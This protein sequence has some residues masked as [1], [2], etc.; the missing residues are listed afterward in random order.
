MKAAVWFG[1]KDVRVM[2]VPEPSAPRAGEVKIKV[3][4]CGICG[5]DLHEYLAGP[6]FINTE[7][8][9]LTGHKAPVILGHEF[10]GDIVEVG[11]GVDSL[12][13]GDR[14]TADACQHCGKCYFCQR[15]MTQLC[16]QVAFTGLNANGAFAEY[17]NVPV[18][19]L[20]KLSDNISY[21]AGALIEPLAVGF[22]AVRQ[23]PLLAG[24]SVVILGAGTIGLSTLQA[25]RAAG[26]SKI[27]V[28]EVARAR[29]EYALKLGA[30][31][32]FDP[33]EVDVVQKVR[34][35][36]GGL[37]ADVSLE[38]IGHEKTVPLAIDL[39]RSAGKV[40]LVGI[41]ERESSMNFFGVV[42]TEKKIT[43][44]LCYNGEFAPVI[45]LLGD[46]RLQAEPLI[47]G[48]IKIDDIVNKGFEELVNNKEQNIKI[49]VTPW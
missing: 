42:A 1:R 48:K 6:I 7:P 38:C 13:V 4:W 45:D 24:E 47:T 5:T 43:G 18:N 25:A 14:V 26:A 21:E 30:T 49:I 2:D 15:N 46:G 20:Y 40:V 3:Q 22:H 11:P 36:T 29:K 8:H 34:E 39:A 41:P 10:A 33:T 44:C 27:F 12:K 9:P 35:A 16:Q 37:G 28:I 19:T 31:A 32:V 17:V 23:A